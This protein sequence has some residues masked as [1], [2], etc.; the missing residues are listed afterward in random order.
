M[1]P[2]ANQELESP[3]YESILNGWFQEHLYIPVVT[4]YHCVSK[5]AHDTTANK[6][7][8]IDVL[9]VPDTMVSSILVEYQFFGLLLSS[10]F[11]ITNCI[12]IITV[13]RN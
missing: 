8:I 10:W 9:D 6:S 3:T 13:H 4:N 11:I 12:D 5:A 2:L 7:N 1:L